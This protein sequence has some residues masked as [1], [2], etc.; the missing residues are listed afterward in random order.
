MQYIITH[1]RTPSE[2]QTGLHYIDVIGPFSL[3][4]LQPISGIQI[5][6]CAAAESFCGKWKGLL[7]NRT[8]VPY[9]PC[10]YLQQG[11]YAA[12]S[13]PSWPWLPIYSVHKDEKSAYNYIVI[14]LICVV[15]SAI[16]MSLQLRIQIWKWTPMPC[17][18]LIT[19]YKAKNWV[20]RER[21][22]DIAGFAA[23]IQTRKA[24]QT[25]DL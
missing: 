3:F 10:I 8:A 18:V 20:L 5:T 6:L 12:I 21:S 19:K 2:S 13:L 11:L 24:Q 14:G 17:L 22:L 4:E 25:A 16:R 7:R 1:R 9:P 23:E 15:G